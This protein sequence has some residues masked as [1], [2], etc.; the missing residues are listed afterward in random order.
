M[1]SISNGLRKAEI[2]DHADVHNID[3]Y[4]RFTQQVD[5]CFEEFIENLSVECAKKCVD[6]FYNTQ[7]IVWELAEFM[8]ELSTDNASSSQSPE[9]IHEIVSKISP[10]L[11]E[12]IRK[13][14]A[15]NILLKFYNFFLLPIRFQLWLYVQEKVNTLSD[16]ELS[17]LFEVEQIKEKLTNDIKYFTG[18]LNEIK[19]VEKKF[20]VA[21]A[22]FSYNK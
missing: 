13:R 17:S 8:S 11:W 21:S 14:I 4:P 1:G 9:D 3:M 2:N 22:E 19:E 6:E 18:H 10:I 15:K 5:A 16:D 12:N 7:T 20:L